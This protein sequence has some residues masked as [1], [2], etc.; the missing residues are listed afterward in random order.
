MLRVV[1]VMP[2]NKNE[3]AKFLVHELPMAAFT[4]RHVD[5]TGT[6]QVRDELA[7]FA[8]HMRQDA[9][10]SYKTPVWF[11]KRRTVYSSTVTVISG[12]P[13]GLPGKFSVSFGQL[14]YT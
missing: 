11:S 13:P 6:L 10:R 2:R 12:L 8:R 7:N 3:A 1:A 14:G 4:A 5:K 9:K